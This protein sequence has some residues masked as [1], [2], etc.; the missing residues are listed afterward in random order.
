[1]SSCDSFQK[2]KQFKDKVNPIYWFVFLVIVLK[3]TCRLYERTALGW[4]QRLGVCIMWKDRAEL[5][6]SADKSSHWG[7]SARDLAWSLPFWVGDTVWRE[8]GGLWSQADIGSY[9]GANT[10][11]ACDLGLSSRCY[12]ALVSSFVTWRL[13]HYYFMVLLWRLNKTM[14]EYSEYLALNMH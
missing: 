11:Q 14:R 8:D 5:S 13:K 2:L 10:S 4:G 3:K 1:M 7:L 6:I 12:C 9:A